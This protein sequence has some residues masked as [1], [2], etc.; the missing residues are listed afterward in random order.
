MSAI[1]VTKLATYSGHKDC[2]YTVIQGIEPN[3]FFTASG[4]GL[5]VKWDLENPNQGEVFAQVPHSVYAL[6]IDKNTDTLLIGENFM[7]LHFI[8]LKVFKPP[9]NGSSILLEIFSLSTKSNQGR[10]QVWRIG[11]VTKDG[12]YIAG[13]S[14]P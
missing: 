6:C 14:E 1:E 5:V 8:D 11:M 12:W 2:I 3:V 7:G 10:T 4:D 9:E 13:C